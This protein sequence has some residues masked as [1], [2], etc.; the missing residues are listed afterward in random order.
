MMGCLKLFGFFILGIIYLL[1]LAATPLVALILG[2]I[3]FIGYVIWSKEQKIRVAKEQKIRAAKETEE[4][5]K[6]AIALAR[7]KHNLYEYDPSIQPSHKR[8]TSNIFENP[9]G[10]ADSIKSRYEMAQNQVLDAE[11]VLNDDIYQLIQYRNQLQSDLIPKYEAAIRPFFHELCLRDENIP[12]PRELKVALDFVYPNDLQPDAIHR[13][14]TNVF[15]GFSQNVVSVLQGKNL[16][17]LQKGDIASIAI[18][19]AISGISYLYTTSQQRTK[20]EKLQADVD[21]MC[22]EISGAIRTYGKISEGI[23]QERWVHEVAVNCIMRHLDTV[24]QLSSQGKK[25]SELP[26]T[27]QKA[28]EDCYKGGQSLK[29]IMQKEIVKPINRRN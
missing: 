7:Q 23:K 4:E 28:V 11:L 26:E 6:R 27:E 3:T 24:I 9:K 16:T 20:L 13:E 2:A 18:A 14:L 25:L 10:W 21:L 22:E 29:T 1:C 8:S 5:R 19:T 12:T 15:Q 17:Q